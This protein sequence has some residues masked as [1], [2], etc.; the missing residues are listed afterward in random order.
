MDMERITIL[1]NIGS[2]SKKYSVYQGD[3]EI[4]WFHLE[5]Q[6]AEFLASYKINSAFE[7]KYITPDEYKTSIIFV[8]EHIQAAR[9][10]NSQKDITGISLRV[11]VPHVDFAQDMICTPEIITTLK[12]IKEFD[13]IHVNPVL[14]EIEIIENFFTSLPALCFISDSTFHST[15][16]RKI[17]LM[18]DSPVY[19]IG[20]HGLSCESVLSLLKE[21]NINHTKLISVHLGGGSSV[22]AIVQG[23]SVYNSMEFSPLDGILMSSRSGSIDPFAV[24]LYMKTHNLSYEQTLQDLYTKSGL[25]AISGGISNDLRVIREEAFKGNKEA[26]QAIT[27]Y[28]DSIVSHICEALSYTQGIDTLVFTGTIGYRAAYIREMVVEKL[29][30]LGLSLDHTD[31]IEAHD[32]C[33]D[34][35]SYNSK[36]KIYTVLVD[37]MKEMHRHTQKLLQK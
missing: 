17:P 37:E 14:E 29:T 27:Q 16:R 26:K 3:L 23:S 20:Y 35:S 11:V 9:V 10:I 12:R 32:S 31:N 33:F 13:P 8:C 6:G 2:A 5:R 21:Q 36:A 19:T 34:I 18:F 28:I 22:S 7:K 25:Y 15:S 4:A 1:S 24:L 30:W